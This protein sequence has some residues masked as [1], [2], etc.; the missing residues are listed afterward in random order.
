MDQAAPTQFR[1][2]AALPVDLPVTEPR[3]V[4]ASA[5]ALTGYGTVVTDP[6]DHK[7]EIVQWPAQGW[8]PIDPGTGDEAGTTEG[9]FSFWWQGEV[10]YG[11][12]EAV[13][14]QYLLG[15]SCDPALASESAPEKARDQVRLWHV[16]YHPDGGQLFYP[17]DGT[18]FVVPLAKPGD[19]LKPEDFVAFYC[20]GSF[21]VCIHP[22]IWHEGVFPLAP[23]ARF[24]DKQGRVHARV[25]CNLPK[26]F[27]RLLAVPLR[28]PSP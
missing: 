1:M 19:D 25:S 6:N 9:I 13:A 20:D 5:E 17:L 16:N 18:P 23:K 4:R 24:F 7:V 21:G 10:L 3:L 26:E 15:W 11:R 2:P 22:G 28:E 8:R 27:G 12:N 14:D